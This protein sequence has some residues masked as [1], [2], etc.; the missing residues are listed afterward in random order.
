MANPKEC[1]STNDFD[2]VNRGAICQ[3]L[4]H[5]H[6]D[7]E[8][9][10]CHP[11][12]VHN[13]VDPEYLK[14][15][16][17]GQLK[18]ILA[19]LHPQA[20]DQ[21]LKITKKKTLIH[22]ILQHTIESSESSS[23]ES[24]SQDK[25]SHLTTQEL[26]VLLKKKGLSSTGLKHQLIDRLLGE[27]VDY[28]DP[29]TP[30]PED[31]HTLYVTQLKQILA[32]R[33]LSTDGR[34]AE[35]VKRVKGIGKKKPRRRSQR[36]KKK[37]RKQSKV[38]PPKKEEPKKRPPKDASRVEL[39]DEW[40]LLMI[41]SSE[42]RHDPE[43]RIGLHSLHNP[44][45][46]DCY[47]HSIQQ[48]FTQLYPDRTTQEWRMMA[49]D[50]LLDRPDLLETSVAYNARQGGDQNRSRAA[51]R[52]IKP[53]KLLDRIESPDP[54][55][56]DSVSRDVRR[57]Y[58]Q[59]NYWADNELIRALEEAADYSTIYLGVDSTRVSEA[60]NLDRRY[61]VIMNYYEGA[62][63]ED[64]EVTFHDGRRARIFDGWA[65]VP[66]AIR[67]QVPAEFIIGEGRAAEEA[68]T[69]AR[70]AEQI[71][72]DVREVR[73]IL[74]ITS[75]SDH[76]EDY[77]E[78]FPSLEAQ[79]PK[80]NPNQQA[81]LIKF[82]SSGHSELETAA[83]ARVITD[84][85]DLPYDTISDLLHETD[86]NSDKVIALFASKRGGGKFHSRSRIK[87]RIHRRLRIIYDY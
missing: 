78:W 77:T 21:T 73:S 74:E 1:N 72:A 50:A 2:L 80:L 48:A 8:K 46:G 36:S 86:Y 69:D 76:E 12:N 84:L 52:N 70:P 25:Y 19:S 57:V 71:E 47:F 31:P 7:S 33:H 56:R 24:T 22:R 5:C 64:I 27:E 44:G 43:I 55:G 20:A 63:Y 13:P 49:V 82:A 66:Q 40:N 15:L 30:I 60:V 58:G 3:S 59:A 67:D 14:T 11:Q 87:R 42:R 34:K 35:L 53:G 45:G 61:F 51:W 37:P 68:R 4:D 29:S 81:S 10:I 75:D 39:R 38:T 16:T 6:W 65:T 54:V 18:N 23:D 41:Q 32:A 79:F 26:R 17:L 85:P 62:H 28:N 9:Y 83:F